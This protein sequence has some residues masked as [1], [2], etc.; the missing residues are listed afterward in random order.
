MPFFNLDNSTAGKDWRVLTDASRWLV[1]TAREK[2]A[3]WEM[4]T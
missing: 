2:G 3:C 4:L 1:A